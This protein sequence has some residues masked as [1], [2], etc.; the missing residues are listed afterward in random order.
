M[1]NA[2]LIYL[3]EILDNQIIQ[4][5]RYDQDTL[6]DMDLYSKLKVHFEHGLCVFDN[7]ENRLVLKFLKP[8]KDTN[9]NL[10]GYYQNMLFMNSF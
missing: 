8:Y 6:N 10:F 3:N 7:I 2:E 9:K 5:N 4:L 1:T